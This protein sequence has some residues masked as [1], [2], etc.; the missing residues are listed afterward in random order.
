MLTT[1]KPYTIEDIPFLTSILQGCLNEIAEI[2]IEMESVPHSNH[3]NSR[4]IKL[5]RA[6]E[7]ERKVL[8]DVSQDIE[9][10]LSMRIGGL[11]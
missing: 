10:I 11:K 1:V 6:E 7:Y 9:A 8:R 4:Y 2:R 3:G 5:C